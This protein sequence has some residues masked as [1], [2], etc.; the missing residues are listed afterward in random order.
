MTHDSHNC[1]AYK[2]SFYFVLDMMRYYDMEE[3]GVGATSIEMSVKMSPRFFQ[4][5][6]RPIEENKVKLRDYFPES[7]LFSLD[8]K[9]ELTR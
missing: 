1:P 9:N 7:W 5:P 8:Y 6:G 2:N 4:D 3:D